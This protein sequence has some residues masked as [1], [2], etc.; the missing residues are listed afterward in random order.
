[1]LK[2]CRGRPA[3]PGSAFCR[4][5][6]RAGDRYLQ[7]KVTS[8]CEKCCGVLWSATANFS[9]PARRDMRS[10][11]DMLMSARHLHFVNAQWSPVLPEPISFCCIISGTQ[12]CDDIELERHTRPEIWR[13]ILRRE[14]I[15]AGNGEPEMQ[16]SATL[17]LSHPQ[18]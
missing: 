6:L 16:T 12:Q 5:R 3:M 4:T 11:P 9:A 18:C 13:Q 1:M 15:E 17:T 10:H 2:N 7:L 14:G 8:Y